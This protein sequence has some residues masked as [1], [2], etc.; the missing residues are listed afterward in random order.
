MKR[1]QRAFKAT[2]RWNQLVGQKLHADISALWA[3]SMESRAVAKQVLPTIPT[4]SNTVEFDVLG[5][6]IYTSSRD[7][8]WILVPQEQS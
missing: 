2:R 1:L 7:V 4:T 5:A 3:T 6:Q 8:F